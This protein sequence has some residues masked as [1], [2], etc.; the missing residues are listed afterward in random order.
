MGVVK[1]GV[2]LVALLLALHLTDAQMESP[3][4]GQGVPRLETTAVFVSAYLDRLLDVN[5]DNYRWEAVVYFYIAWTDF[6]AF[7]TMQAQSEQVLTNSSFKCDFYCSNVLEQALCC[8]N[9]Y[10]PSFFFKNAYGFPQD[11]EIMYPADD[12]SMLWEVRVH[13][14]YYQ[15]MDFSHFPFDSFDLALELR[16]YDPTILIS[17]DWLWGANHTGVTVVP[18]SGGK[19]IYTIGRGDDASSWAVTDYSLETYSVDMGSWF[20]Q[21]SDLNSDPYDP[22][23][24]APVNANQ[25]GGYV[26]ESGNLLNVFNGVTDQHLAILITV[27]R[28]WKPSL[29]NAVLPVVLVFTLGLMTFFTSESSLDTRLEIVVTL[30]LALTAVQFVVIGQIPTS[31][32]VVPTQQLVLTTYI[33]LFL[34]AIESIAKRKEAW[35]RYC[36]L[37]DQG[38]LEGGQNPTLASAASAPQAKLDLEQQEANSSGIGG[39]EKGLRSVTT[40]GQMT[41]DEAFGQYIEHMVD[42]LSAVFLAVGYSVTAILIFTL[43]SGYIDLFPV[44]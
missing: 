29:I 43:Q 4:K 37:R 31:S 42:N 32:Y 1:L 41:A 26:D 38:K 18:S 23:P 19:K 21:Y 5:E 7:D 35:R 14:I 15:P 2:T 17:T 13:G 36:K 28:F 8:S 24:L 20:S 11:R 3:L 22:M 27:E 30:F 40:L 39:E 34:L 10:L 16:L 44:A 12:G 25:T 33:F 9:I 6:S